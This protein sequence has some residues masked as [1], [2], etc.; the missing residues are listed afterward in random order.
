MS[1]FYTVEE[2]SA[3][4]NVPADSIREWISEGKVSA[5]R[6]AGDVVLRNHEVQRLMS[7]LSASEAAP[8]KP[9]TAYI[10]ASGDEASA[11]DPAAY[12][13]Y[14]NDDSGSEP[15][16]PSFAPPASSFGRS[17]ASFE[18]P[19]SRRT[20]SVKAA[21][22][23]GKTDYHASLSLRSSDLDGIVPVSLDYSS[24][25]DRELDE[26]ESRLR[27]ESMNSPLRSCAG[28]S[29]S[30]GR[31][32]DKANMAASFERSLEA[33]VEPLTRA[34]ARLLKL[35]SE[36]REEMHRST[37]AVI[38]APG[39]SAE[40][41][42][43]SR[44]EAGLKE[45][46]EAAA[47][48][49]AMAEV[50]D[51]LS[52]MKIELE[53]FRDFC[54]ECISVNESNVKAALGS[55]TA[56]LKEALGEASSNAAVPP[57]A[58]DKL[59]KKYELLTQKYNNLRSEHELVVSEKATAGNERMESVLNRLEV[60]RG[61]LDA[62]GADPEEFA[63]KIVSHID[64]LNAAKRELEEK[65]EVSEEE[66]SS[67]RMLID[68]LQ[69][70][71]RSLKDEKDK[72]KSAAAKVDDDLAE[73][74]ELRAV[75]DRLQNDAS[76]SDSALGRLQEQ[77][78][79]LKEHNKEL[80]RRLDER[81]DSTEGGSEDVEKLRAENEALAGKCEQSEAVLSEAQESY[82]QISAEL[83]QTKLELT[84]ARDECDSAKKALDELRSQSDN[85]NSAYDDLSIA[86]N[87]KEAEL[88]KAESELVQMRTQVQ[89]A[90]AQT[91]ELETMAAEAH[92]ENEEISAQ[93]ESVKAELEDACA[94]RDNAEAAVQELEKK[95]EE[96][97]A[98]I[99]SVRNELELRIE[100][101]RSESA[102]AVKAAESKA[103]EALNALEESK[104]ESEGLKA[105]A[106]KFDSE[107]ARLLRRINTL[108]ASNAALTAE[109]DETREMEDSYDEV[110]AVE[111]RM[112]DQLDAVN[113]ELSEARARLKEYEDGGVPDTDAELE[114]ALA[115][116]E[117]LR[118]ENEAL[119]QELEERDSAM[120][121][122]GG[123]E[124]KDRLL[125]ESME[126]RRH[127]REELERVKKSLFD[128]QQL[129]ERERKEWADIVRQQ[130]KGK[131]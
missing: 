118:A 45:L 69:N 104:A 24:L 64:E 49:T 14:D 114:D 94:G 34:Q 35:F 44:I 11:I 61:P 29:V 4:L 107:K 90:K 65:W 31:E 73:L 119:Q 76:G 105:V 38:P 46:K 88:E 86:Y 58:L 74:E 96:L 117:D 126:D 18:P 26:Y 50:K 28:H 116:L 72:M 75:C 48:S 84:A 53:S 67:F 15:D 59:Q 12:Y 127:L 51:T 20:A 85:S 102:E 36:S 22:Q 71:N 25:Y 78:L 62:D 54:S 27:Y 109:L 101:V 40:D 110:K 17:G 108:Q 13:G 60:L 89:S 63:E 93:L 10:G 30:D 21:Q 6:R 43:L 125:H 57:D 66:S 124:E 82:K 100:E 95:N 99:E 80:Q 106:A 52:D 37:P 98:S 5:S 120:A 42:A 83:E 56:E 91:A 113:L 39:S 19:V 77:Y 23:S 103:D 2:V 9:G 87:S 129:Y 111:V 7:E 32:A 1:K 112:Q 115:Q 79:E 47:G 121:E 128:Q 8:D 68:N 70:E 16:E 55:R 81:A 41:K 123:D 3:M 92:K 97:E 130:V 33:V 131:L 122:N